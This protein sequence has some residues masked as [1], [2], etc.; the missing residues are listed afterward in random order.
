MR[1]GR[2]HWADPD[3]F[4]RPAPSIAQATRALARM[5]HPELN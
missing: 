4:S 1:T 5:L 2:V 3:L